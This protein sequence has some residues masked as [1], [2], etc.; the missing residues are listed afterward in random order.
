MYSLT[1]KNVCERENTHPPPFVRS[2]PAERMPQPP[3]PCLCSSAEATT[4]PLEAADSGRRRPNLTFKNEM[5][6]AQRTPKRLHLPPPL[7]P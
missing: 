1:S 7:T 3:P 6:E 4:A 5:S 2:N